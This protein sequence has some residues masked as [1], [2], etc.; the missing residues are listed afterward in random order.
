MVL[1]PN[2]VTFWDSEFLGDIIQ[3]STSGFLQLSIIHNP[4]S[5][6]EHFTSALFLLEHLVIGIYSIKSFLDTTFLYLSFLYHLVISKHH[7]F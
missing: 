1:F 4:I 2:K 6:S 3:T 7:P 5:V